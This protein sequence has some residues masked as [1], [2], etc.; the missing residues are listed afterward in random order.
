MI[1]DRFYFKQSC[2]VPSCVAI[3]LN[4]GSVYCSFLEVT[5]WYVKIKLNSESYTCKCLG[6][7]T[8]NEHGSSF[9]T[10]STYTYPTICIGYTTSRC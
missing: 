10:P 9:D 5:L 3:G 8:R 2:R 1:D 6:L 7:Y 4:R